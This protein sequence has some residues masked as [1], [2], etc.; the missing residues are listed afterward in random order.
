VHISASL[1]SAPLGLLRQ[2]LKELEEARVDSLHFDIEDGAFVPCMTLG[3]KLIGDLRPHTGF[4]F[5]VHLMM[6]SPEWLLPDLA[7]SGANRISVHLEAC[8]YP[9]R[10]L[11]SIVSLGITAGLAFNPITPIPDLSYLSPY[12]SFMLILT[13]EPELPDAPFLPEILDKL[14]DAKSAWKGSQVEWVVDGG[15]DP[16]NLPRVAQAGA[17]AVVVGRAIF[18]QDSIGENTIALRAAVAA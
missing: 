17:D 6:H 8:S 10:T 14:R 18:N 3:T 16:Q 2:T 7:R 9:R 12:L 1:A 13:T 5:D 4:P 11:R 15:I